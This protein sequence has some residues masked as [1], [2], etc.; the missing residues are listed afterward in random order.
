MKK[1]LS[2]LLAVLLLVGCQYKPLKQKNQLKIIV[3]SDLHYFL[4]DYYQDCEWFEEEMLHGDGKM[5]TYADEILDVFI[6]EVIQQNPDLLILT[7]DLTFNGEIGSH[8]ALAEKLSTLEDKGIEVAVIPGNHDVDNIFAK[9]YGKDDYFEVDNIDAGD[10]QKIYK[11]LGYDISYHQHSDSL[12]YSVQLNQ[13]Y[14]LLMLDSNAHQLTGSSLDVGGYLT[15]STLS[16]MTKELQIAKDEG[17]IPIVAMHHNLAIHNSLFNQGYV[18]KDHEN[19][20]KI[21]KEYH[22]PLVLTGHMHCQN[23]KQIDG[24]YDIAS[25]SLLDTPLQFGI[26]TINQQG[27]DYHTHSLKISTDSDDYFDIVSLNK[28]T[29]TFEKVKDKKVR[30][31]MKDVLVKANRYYFTG[32]MYQHIEEIKNMPGYSYYF[33]SEGENVSFYKEYFESMMKDTNDNQSLNL[34]Y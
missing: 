10:F 21:F 17:K 28:F 32:N 23:I 25:S 1:I 13:D 30:E 18:I 31:Q 8:Q 33:Q 22:V 9:G 3:A 24:I 2:C 5:V 26:L 6:K 15:T 27:I 19:I 14:T 11:N 4:K 29:E 16:W 34:R 12:S 20:A 7:G